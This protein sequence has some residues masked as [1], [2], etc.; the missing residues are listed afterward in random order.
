MCVCVCVGGG[1]RGEELVAILVR[2]MQPEHVRGCLQD[3]CLHFQ[4]TSVIL[5]PGT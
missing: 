2:G 5:R 4:V 1:V 3:N